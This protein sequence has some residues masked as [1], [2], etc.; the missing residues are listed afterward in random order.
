VNTKIR[1]A[2]EVG[3]DAKVTRL[4]GSVSQAEVQ[5]IVAA[6]NKQPHIDGIIIQVYMR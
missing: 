3:L 6:L 5:T 2:K 4:P 1:V